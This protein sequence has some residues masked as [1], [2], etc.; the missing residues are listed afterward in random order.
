MRAVNFGCAALMPHSFL[1]SLEQGGK[2]SI[3]WMSA[4][5]RAEI[6]AANRSLQ[7]LLQRAG[8]FK[9]VQ[10]RLKRQ[11]ANGFELRSD[12]FDDSFALLRLER[13]GGVE[14]AA[15]GGQARERGVQDL[16]LPAGLAGDLSGCEA[17]A[18]LGVACERAGSTAGHVAEDQVEVIELGRRLGGVS[19]RGE[20]V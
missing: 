1:S 6:V 11:S 20:Y 12:G 3:A 9:V 10:D 5:Q 16:L 15:P 8:C 17:V 2:E 19:L 14:Q 4:G 13:A 18:N 7:C